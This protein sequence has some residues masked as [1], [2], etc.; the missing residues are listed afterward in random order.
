MCDV[1]ICSDSGVGLCEDDRRILEG[2]GADRHIS[3]RESSGESK[4]STE[5]FGS[6]DSNRSPEA[7]FYADK[8]FDDRNNLCDRDVFEAKNGLNE[9]WVSLSA[10]KA[11]S[12]KAKVTCEGERNKEDKYK[13]DDDDNNNVEH[14]TDRNKQGNQDV[15]K[16]SGC[17]GE[18]DTAIFDHLLSIVS[19]KL[20]RKKFHH[21][22]SPIL[23]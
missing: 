3:F 2:L 15:E 12:D 5:R 4:I 13:L 14:E 1:F 9:S 20:K 11:G 17:A 16:H 22:P 23:W 7:K 6:G 18:V 8:K 19:Q 10:V 21:L